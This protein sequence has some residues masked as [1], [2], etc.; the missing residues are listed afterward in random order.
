VDFVA[1]SGLVLSGRVPTTVGPVEAR[2]RTLSA[3]DPVEGLPRFD[4]QN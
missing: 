4:G 1:H 3:A 2:R